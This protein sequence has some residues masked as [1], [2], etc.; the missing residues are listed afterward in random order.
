A[1][2]AAGGLALGER[3]K[4][5]QLEKDQEQMS[6]LSFQSLGGASSRSVLGAGPGATPVTITPACSQSSTSGQPGASTID[7]DTIRIGSAVAS[8]GGGTAASTGGGTAVSPSSLKP[9]A[10]GEGASGKPPVSS[11]P[12]SQ[13]DSFFAAFEKETVLSPAQYA[14][15][16]KEV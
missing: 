16:M 7:N 8:T 15:K 12:K 10:D 1:I 5:L 2:T 4:M 14:E 13:G 6:R 9:K 3:G 11:P